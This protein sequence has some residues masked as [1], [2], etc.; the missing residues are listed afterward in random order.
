M[1]SDLIPPA[2]TTDQLADTY[3]REAQW[4]LDQMR[5]FFWLFWL[6]WM[7][8]T[9]I[10]GYVRLVNGDGGAPLFFGWAVAFLLF[11]LWG[12]GGHLV[13]RRRR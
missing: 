3:A 10:T 13:Y 6:G 8:V 12:T 9:A 5:F 11:I 1:P 4:G 7:I 2:N